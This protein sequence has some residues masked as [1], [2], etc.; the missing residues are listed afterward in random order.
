MAK[1][2]ATV[3]VKLSRVQMY[4]TSPLENQV[5]PCPPP[6]DSSSGFSITAS[7]ELTIIACS[8]VVVMECQ[9]SADPSVKDKGKPE[10]GRGS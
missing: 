4:Q 2:A 5:K 10:R 6:G 1:K 7:R 8:G 3:C 9:H